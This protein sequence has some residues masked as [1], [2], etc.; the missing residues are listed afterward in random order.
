MP[1]RNVDD[2]IKGSRL[3]LPMEDLKVKFLAGSSVKALA[4]EY[5]CSRR[6]I[7]SRL[8]FMGIEM[9]NC[10]EA[11]FTR[12]KFTT[13]EER[14]RLSLFGS[15]AVV[16]PPF[17]ELCTRAKHRQAEANPSKLQGWEAK[18]YEVAGSIGLVP[19]FAVGPYNVDFLIT[20]S[21]VTVEVLSRGW[22]SCKRHQT[23]FRKRSIYIRDAGFIAVLV[24]CFDGEGITVDCVE[25]LKSLVKKTR[26]DESM[27]GEHHVIRGNGDPT[28]FG[29]C[30]LDYLSGVMRF[31][32]GK[33][34]VR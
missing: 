16:A 29:S 1:K 17:E 12:M 14:K 3:R 15:S 28:T 31:H 27:L 11:M 34:V 5:G 10:S 7:Q 8:E 13:P 20:G 32:Q 19:Q 2:Y 18:F 22:H 21:P 6:A 33:Y 4:S 9:R 23:T 25:Y 26:R 30:N 24:W